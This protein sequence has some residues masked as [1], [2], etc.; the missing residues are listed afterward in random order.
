[1]TPPPR[2]W[3]V[4]GAVA[5]GVFVTL[6]DE[7]GVN[8]ALP[9]IADHFDA[10]IPDVQ[11][12]VLGFLLTV[13]ALMLPVG[14]FSDIV[15]HRR[16]YT[17]GLAVFTLGALLAALAPS[18]VV[19]I[20]FRV[21][22]GAGAAMVQATSLPIIATSFPPHERGKGI[23]LF[24]GVLAFGAICGPVVGGGVVSFLEWRFFFLLSV[25][26]GVASTFLALRVLTLRPP[27]AGAGGPDGRT[28]GFDWLGAGLA[29]TT[30]TLFLLVVS[31]GNE[32]GW[33]A[34][35]TLAGFAVVA[36]LIAA[37]LAWETRASSPL[38]PLALFKNRVF[39]IGQ[40]VMFL[41]V[42]GNSSTFFLVPFYVQDVAGRSP[43]L[44]GLIVAG[45][46]AAFITTGPVVG[47]LSDRWSWRLFVPVGM[48]AG[49]AA[50]ALLSRT[51]ED[52][53]LAYVAGDLALLG[54]G[55]GFIFSPAQNAV[56][57]S[58]KAGQ[59][60]IV[61]AFVNMA[62]NAG[63]LSSVAVGAA[64]VTATMAANGYEPSLDALRESL[65]TGIEAAFVS[66]MSRAFAV[67][68]GVIF[69]GLLISLW[70]G[71]MGQRRSSARRS[72]E[73]PPGND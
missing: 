36:G 53:P 64:I 50:M 8:Q 43:A 28:P 58:I 47:A 17:V 38:L 34:P 35:A 14:R 16:V 44:S 1:M 57:G 18:L 6:L 19:L 26:I 11:W 32:V 69:V 30:L 60:G 2:K 29:T 66:G 70:P 22:Q 9:S 10:T 21:L 55:M 68:A 51:T 13:G 3:A 39:L 24:M 12:I 45:L 48:A 52:T 46:P 7:I 27:P 59:E 41:V 56:Y 5:P 54:F 67:G 4:F 40:A 15:G 62:R 42:T 25:P 20:L 49:C 72:L 61:T 71:G 31:F 37:F 33:R 65:D 63:Q 73:A 23:G